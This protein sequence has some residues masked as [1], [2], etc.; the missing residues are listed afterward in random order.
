MPFRGT[1]A[2]ISPST[3]VKSVPMELNTVVLFITQAMTPKEKARL[4]VEKAHLAG[5]KIE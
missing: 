2:G 5:L 1:D 3:M 4:L